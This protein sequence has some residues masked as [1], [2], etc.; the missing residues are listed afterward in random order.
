MAQIAEDLLLL[1]LD[2]A[3]ARPVL[4]TRRRQRVLAAATLL[5]L[6]HCRRVSV[7]ESGTHLM[8]RCGIGPDD[9]ASRPAI[10]L[11]ARRPMTAAD[12]ISR[13]RRRT[14]PHLLG[15]LVQ[16][17]AIHQIQLRGKGFR[18]QPGWLTNDRGRPTATRAALLAVLFDDRPPAPTTAA[19]ISLLYSVD[20]L[21]TLLSLDQR[22]RRWVDDRAGEIASGSWVNDFITET[23]T[24]NLAVTA[25][26]VCAALLARR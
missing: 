8:L 3:S 16:I 25:A 11:L 21:C 26:A 9:P 2:N 4:E 6:A 18:G 10:E 7:S 15:H 1:L 23:A 12:A 17:G 20:G 19:L 5:D 13:L 24:V 14:E 22:G